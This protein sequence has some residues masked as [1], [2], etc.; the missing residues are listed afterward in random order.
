MAKRTGNCARGRVMNGYVCIHGHFY[1]PPRENPWLEEIQKQD[2]ASP[3]HDWNERV[4]YECYEPNAASRILDDE[5][6]VISI[7]NNYKK[8]SFNFGPTLL[9]W[10]ERHRPAVYRAVLEADM[11]S[12]KY[13]SGHGSAIAQ[14]YNHIIMPLAVRRD[15]ATQVQWGIAD[16]I[17]R[18]K[19]TP[20]GMWLPETAVDYETLEILADEGISFTILAP[21]QAL[22]VR[23]TGTGEW[24]DVHEAKI[25]TKRAYLCNLPSGKSITIFFYDGPIAHEVS[26]GDLLRDGK[27][28]A[29]RLLQP[30]AGSE[31]N[32]L[33]HIATDGETY[34]HHHRF[35]DMALAYCIHHI[36][37]NDLARITVYGEY[38]EKFP[39][40][41][42]VEIAENTSWS[43][44]HGVERWRSNCGCKTGRHPAYSQEWRAPLRKAM[45]RLRD[46]LAPFFEK[47][48]A[49][50]LK[51]PWT[52]RD[53]Y[54]TLILDR[55][56]ENIETFLQKHERKQLSQQ[57]RVR[58]L[59]LL[60]MQRNAQLMFTSCGWFFE[61]ISDI[62]TTQA[63]QY[64]ARAMQLAR[65]TNG[66]DLE[67][68]YRNILEKAKSNR[69]EY[70]SG[71]DVYDREAAG[72]RIT[73]SDV[74]AH[75]AVLSLFLD[76]N[77]LEEVYCYR[78]QPLQHERIQEGGMTL[79]AGQVDIVSTPVTEQCAFSF[80]VLH[81]GNQDIEG[82]V[83]D[84]VDEPVFIEMRDA[85]KKA[86]QDQSPAG[87]KN[88]M[89]RY[90]G[91][92]TYSLQ[93]LFAD[94]QRD[95]I[96]RILAPAVQDIEVELVKKYNEW[97][98]LLQ[99]LERLQYPLSQEI[100]IVG[101]LAVHAKMRMLL[102]S[103]GKDI[104]EFL[105]LIDE[106]KKFSYTLNEEILLRLSM[107]LA[108]LIEDLNP[109]NEG[110]G[111]KRLRMLE[112]LVS[113]ILTLQ[114]QIDL[115]KAQDSYFRICTEHRKKIAEKAGGGDR[116]AQAWLSVFDRLGDNLNI[117]C[118]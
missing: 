14:A 65:E 45:D 48:A 57:E 93:S 19:R 18:F 54:I 43:C 82:R 49:A 83:G 115:R 20:E 63:M 75:Y 113:A 26:F 8:M 6:R 67:P 104:N 58:S 21:H 97:Q 94:E 59:K 61:E 89:E 98:P 33:V 109:S 62:E 108:G 53:Q 3:F 1:Q 107:I 40:A 111:L 13:F 73:L 78:A 36:E 28:F 41:Y 102:D 116:S 47:G 68:E 90:I 77:G 34:G 114:M 92:K 64:G 118:E 91:T 11:E 25:D 106:I 9:A 99:E 60:E 96:D 37:S 84:A 70:K 39:P 22:R 79:S 55:S 100:A 23:R 17:S 29:E 27:A 117:Q 32:T 7:I 51:D 31:K 16:F 42:E 81:A 87:V 2:E 50:L 103:D 69:Q 66:P 72:K 44:V 10:I 38:L 110:K 46:E 88:I 15:K 5:K 95:I 105:D 74:G 85:L 80:A 56:S 35:G 12:R 71:R 52:A 30:L 24:T 112:K 4:S 86:M 76:G 101:N